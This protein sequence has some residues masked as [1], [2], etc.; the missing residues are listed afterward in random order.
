MNNLKKFKK[1]ALVTGAA[2]RIGQG[3]AIALAER[4]YDIALHYNQSQEK[5]LDVARIIRKKGVL[6]ELFACDL[7]NQEEVLLLLEKVH[8]KFSHLNLLVNNASIFKPSGLDRKSLKELDAHWLVNFRSP[9]V[10]TAEFSRLCKKGQIIN[11]LDTKINKNKTEH[12]G[13]LLSKKCLGEFTKMAAV[14]L[15]PHIRV[16]GISPGIILP[17]SGQGAGYLKK[18]AGQIPLL[19]SG[20]VAYILQAINFLIDN[21]FV[22]GQIISVDGGEQLT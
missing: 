17:P 1:A 12:V 18:R 13:Y 20:G 8:K 9:F 14:L 7:H 21:E 22:T 5:A 6:C 4:G 15:A 3:I 2:Q 16:N 19:K 10:L 11:I